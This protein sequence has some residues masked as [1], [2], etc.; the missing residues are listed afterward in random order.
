MG[1]GWIELEMKRNGFF[2]GRVI[3]DSFILQ[4]LDGRVRKIRKD[5]GAKE[6]QYGYFIWYKEF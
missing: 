6:K 1:A 4:K 3:Q 5:L 2:V